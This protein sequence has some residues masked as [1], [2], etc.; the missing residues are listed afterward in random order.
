MQ[1][2]SSVLR[3]AAELGRASTVKVSDALGVR[4]Q[5]DQAMH[6]WGPASQDQLN[7]IAELG[8]ER[9]PGSKFA[10]KHGISAR[11][12]SLA[13]LASLGKDAWQQV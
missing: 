12:L 4:G 2:A 6:P 9:Q 8:A 7:N 10:A 11:V 3:P 13:S 1:C 5:A